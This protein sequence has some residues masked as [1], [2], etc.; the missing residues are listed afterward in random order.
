MQCKL[1]PDGFVL[2]D[3]MGSLLARCRIA[4]QIAL[5]GLI[6]VVGVLSIAG[7][8]WWGESQVNQTNAT[9][10]AAREAR[11]LETQAQVAL[12]QARREEKNFLLRHDA[13][14]IANQAAATTTAEK[15]LQML[16]ARLPSQPDLSGLVRQMSQDVQRYAAAFATVLTE[17][18]TVGLDENQGLL[19]ELRNSVHD[20]EAQLAPLHVPAAEIAMLMMRRNEKDFIVRGDASY[21]AALKAQMPPFIAAL[22]AAEVPPDAKQ[23]MLAKMQAYQDSFARFMAGT[24]HQAASVKTLADLYAGIEPRLGEADKRF[25]AEA[26]AAQHDAIVIAEQTNRF[27][28]ISLV[29][30]TGLV[31]GLCWIIGRSIARPIIAVTKAMDGLVSGDLT[32]AIPT[33]ER[34]DEIG[35]MIRV[36]GTFKETLIAAAELRRAQEVAR[37]QAELDKHAALIG[38]AERIESEAASAVALIGERTNAM[39]TT[40]DEMRALSERTGQSADSAMAAAAMALGNAQ[41][42][43]SAAE[44]LSSSIHEISGQ[45]NQSASVV[46]QAVTAGNETRATIEALNERVGRIGA[47]ADIISDIASKTNL[48]ALN[49]TIEAARAGDAGKGFAVVASEVKQLANQTARST[50]EINRHLNEVRSATSAAVTAVGRIETTIGQVNAIAGSIAAAVEEQGAA[51]AEIARNVTETAAAVNEMSGRNAEVSDEAKQAGRYADAV[52]DNAKALNAAVHDLRETMVRTV[53]TSTTEVDRRKAARMPLD[54][55]CRV[56][57]GGRSLPDCRIADISEAGARLAGLSG[58]SVGARGTLR[59][60]GATAALSFVV[61]SVSDEVA[62][63]VFELDTTSEA[64]IRSLLTRIGM[65][66]AA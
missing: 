8:N 25:N 51:T 1:P 54:M 27:V 57:V 21:G 43:A 4:C 52:V 29:V 50:E 39:T 47:V 14:S 49:A 66:H 48:L 40:A 64:A 56:E 36:V 63:V 19:G 61:K 38:M 35:T 59:P 12:L 11:D 28:L 16:E 34:G 60:E 13:A 5:L 22:D 58:V 17:A 41:T 6:G 33:D 7:L 55:R 32:T 24:L 30:I 31:I 23:K 18:K 3:F 65:R 45:V 37:E 44:Q 2:E 10:Q 46:S 42:V 62:G 9:M 20:V 53:R 15:A 26:A